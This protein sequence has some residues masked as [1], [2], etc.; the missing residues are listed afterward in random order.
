MAAEYGGMEAS[1]LATGMIL[2]K[3]LR[4]QGFVVLD[5]EDEYPTFRADI[6]HMLRASTL[7]YQTTIYDG[8]EQ[9]PKALAECLSGRNAGGKLIVRVSGDFRKEK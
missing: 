7:T 5:H 3:R 9:A 4:I 8:I 6:A 2:A 1:T